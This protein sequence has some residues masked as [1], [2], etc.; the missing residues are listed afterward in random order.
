MLLYCRRLTFINVRL[1]P[2]HIRAKY[3]R[4]FVAFSPFIS[5]WLLGIHIRIY[6]KDNK[7]GWLLLV[8]RFE[9]CACLSAIRTCESMN[10]CIEVDAIHLCIVIRG[11]N[12]EY[13]HNQ[14]SSKPY[15]ESTEKNSFTQYIQAHTHTHVHI[16]ISVGKQIFKN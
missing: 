9:Y 10:S 8:Y 11:E 6:G 4:I 16:Y 12:A 14:S 13:A 5:Y 3:T 2:F 7:Y 1:V 15:Y